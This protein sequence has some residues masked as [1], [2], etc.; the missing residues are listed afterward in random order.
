M[1]AVLLAC[2]AL[3]LVLVESHPPAAFLAAASLLTCALAASRSNEDV[4][5]APTLRTR[6]AVVI[7]SVKPGD[8]TWAD[9]PRPWLGSQVLATMTLRNGDTESSVAVDIRV[10]WSLFRGARR[11]VL[12]EVARTSAVIGPSSVTSLD[13]ATRCCLPEDFDPY[14]ASRTF[15]QLVVHAFVSY[16]DPSGGRRSTEASRAWNLLSEAFTPFGRDRQT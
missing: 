11:H 2:F 15:D 9:A 4:G 12:S 5:A 14:P 13:V 8:S 3:V 7:D 16:L 6:P 10:C 1:G